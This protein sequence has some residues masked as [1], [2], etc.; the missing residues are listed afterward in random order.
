MFKTLIG[1][2]LAFAVGVEYARR[3]SIDPWG[4]LHETFRR[5][6]A[7]LKETI[8]YNKSDTSDEHDTSQ[9]NTAEPAVEEVPNGEGQQRD[10]Q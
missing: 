1:I 3:H 6:G 5:S 4:E 9:D 10:Q 7:R 2:T 8:S